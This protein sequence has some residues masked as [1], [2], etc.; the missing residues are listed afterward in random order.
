M[1]FGEVKQILYKTVVSFHQEAIVVWVKTKGVTPKPPYITL[2][3]DNLERSRFS[4]S[5]NEGRHRY[6]NYSFGFEINLYTTGKEIEIDGTV[7][8]A[9]ENTAVED[10]EEFT[11]FLDSDEMTD[12]L[13]EQGI[14]IIMNPP[15]R[16]LSDLIDD[17]KFN[18]RAK[19]DFTVSFIGKADGRYGVSGNKEFH[20]PSGGGTEKYSKAKDL[21]IKKVKVEGKYNE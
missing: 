20:N 5:D 13:S 8:G 4:L 2:G 12:Q 18:Y 6:Y 17:I 10:L 3:Y 16:D 19:V 11:R 15:V 9:Y 7:T 1:T 21:Y 14:T